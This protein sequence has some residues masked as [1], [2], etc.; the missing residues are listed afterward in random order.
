MSDCSCNLK[1][2]TLNLGTKI[3]WSA[4]GP[5]GAPSPN[6]FI[7]TPEEGID[8]LTPLISQLRASVMNQSCTAQFESQMFFQLSEDGCTWDSPQPI[9]VGGAFV[10]G[11]TQN[12]TDWYN[13]TTNY[14]RFIRFGIT[15][16]QVAGTI[17]AQAN[18]SLIIDILL[19]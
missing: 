6:Y 1:V 16:A 15:A 8:S 13:T 5:G 19:K 12:T 11:N 10:V 9:A 3:C 2:K 4:G 18:V 7:Y 14:K 17:V